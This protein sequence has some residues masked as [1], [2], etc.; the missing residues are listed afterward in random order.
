MNKLVYLGLS[1][2][3]LSKKVMYEFW[4]DYVNLKY[5]ENVKLCYMDTDSFNVYIKLDDI[6]KDIL[7]DVQTRFDI[8]NV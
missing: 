5:A 7:K 8:L 6:Y 4:Y 1:V 2:L 3:E